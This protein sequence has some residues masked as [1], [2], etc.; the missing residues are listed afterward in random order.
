MRWE[1]GE[2]V[3]R[4]KASWVFDIAWPLL[5]NCLS[6]P[7]KRL[8]SQFIVVEVKEEDVNEQ[9]PKPAGA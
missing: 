4:E 6:P 2:V 3:G 9:P 1:G 5:S 7:A 8:A